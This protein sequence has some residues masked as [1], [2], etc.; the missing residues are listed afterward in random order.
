MKHHVNHSLHVTFV[1][2][3]MKLSNE[4]ALNGLHFL[5]FETQGT[6]CHN[7]FPSSCCVGWICLPW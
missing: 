1:A 4:K 5:F 6:A 3:P 7:E 2:E